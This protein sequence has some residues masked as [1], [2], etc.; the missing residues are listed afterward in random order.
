MIK[1]YTTSWCPYCQ[2]AKRLLQSKA[3]PYEEIDIEA[4][5]ISREQLADI[6][7]GRSVPQIVL[8][9]K[10]IGGYDNLVRLDTA[11]KL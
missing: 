2:A 8:D 3:I 1:I 4:E 7:G 5:G 9:G 10:P 11:G 6:T